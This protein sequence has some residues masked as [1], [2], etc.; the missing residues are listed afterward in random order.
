[1]EKHEIRFICAEV[2]T[3]TLQQAKAYYNPKLHR[4]AMYEPQN[5]K[6]AKKLYENKLRPFRP[7]EPIEGPKKITIEFAMGIK[8]EKKKGTW[9]TTR[10]DIDNMCKIL[11]DRMTALRFFNDDSE[12]VSLTASKRYVEEGESPNVTIIVEVL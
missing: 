3:A 6:D 2:P 5:V 11:L 7:T 9:K 1:M 4:V 8:S 10:P 12:I